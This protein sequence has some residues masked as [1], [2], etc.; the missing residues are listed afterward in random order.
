MPRRPI[1]LDLPDPTGRRALVTGASDGIGLHI[2]ARLAE[3]GADLV[4]PVRNA[5]KGE[6]AVARIRATAPRASIATPAL[7]LSSLDS[8][9][10][11]GERLRDEGAPLHLLIGNAGVM[12]PP[13]R[14]TTAD[15]HELQLGTNHLGH[16]ALVAGLLPLLRAGSARIVL[17]ISVAAAR[18]SV[19]WDD[20]DQQR[21]YDG[22]RAYRSSKIAS[23]LW[24]LE[25]DR[26]SRAHGWGVTAALAHPG[27]APTSLLAARPELG[28]SRDTASVR[29]IRALSRRGVLAG[30]PESAALPALLAATALAAPGRMYGP[31]G[32]G[33][34]A[35][36]PAEQAL[37]R[38][39]RS[40]ADARRIWAVSAELA[41]AR[42]PDEG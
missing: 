39:L 23:G 41:G 34:T 25:L 6:A 32:P 38:P 33:H 40:E 28:R 36:A 2:A 13:E 4:L 22:A 42:F 18:G 9:A 17:Q 24:G 11:L 14:R 26:R 27:I 10:A 5:A 3:A 30:T 37:Y 29:V 12:T 19:L 35:G 31:S 15:G 20:L 1:H 7:D 8:V 21:S 16:V